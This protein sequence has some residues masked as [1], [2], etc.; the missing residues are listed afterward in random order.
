ML[1]E[2]ITSRRQGE[3][4][5][6]G[7][8]GLRARQHGLLQVHFAAEPDWWEVSDLPITLP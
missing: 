5:R 7:H 4:E 2:V 6:D 8:R 1:Y 3:G